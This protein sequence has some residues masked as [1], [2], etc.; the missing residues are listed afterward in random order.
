MS[1]VCGVHNAYT[2]FID[3]RVDTG[4]GRG[5]GV[6]RATARQLP[7]HLISH[8]LTLPLPPLGPLDFFRVNFRQIFR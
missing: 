2:Y 3:N 6:W 1:V 8:Y 7:S 4:G 5:H